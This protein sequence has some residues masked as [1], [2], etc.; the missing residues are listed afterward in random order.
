MEKSLIKSDPIGEII[1]DVKVKNGDDPLRELLPRQRR[2]LKA[3]IKTKNR[4]EAWTHVYRTKSYESAM[5]ASTR[6]LNAHPE[7]M[8]WIYQISGLS[9]ESF[10][11]VVRD[12]MQANRTQFYKGVK[13]DDPDHYARFKAVEL[14]LRLRGK[15]KSSGGGNQ[16]NIQIITDSDKGIFKVTDGQE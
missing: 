4:V 2:F 3:F 15:D 10:A 6:F 16:M 8:D 5:A 7:V 13:Y 12:G 1:P 14:G 9:D 11:E